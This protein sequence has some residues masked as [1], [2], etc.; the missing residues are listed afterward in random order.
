M[1]SAGT[2]YIID[3]HALIFQ[4][5]HAIQEL[6]APDGRPM[7][8]VFGVTRDLIWL[9]QEVKPDY[10]L[11]AFDRAEPT[12]RDAI[13]PAYKK[14]RPPVPPDLIA[15]EP[16]IHQVL[17]AMNLPVLSLAG[18]EADDLMAT[19]AKKGEERGLDVFICT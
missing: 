9:H 10:L 12:F 16:N 11:C 8:A 19:L 5:F 18:F 3:A 4:M 17:E 15:Q 2:M 13:Y 1:A 14:N 6:N 7:N